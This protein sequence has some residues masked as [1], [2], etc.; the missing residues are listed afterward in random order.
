MAEERI[1]NGIMVEQ[2]DDCMDGMRDNPELGKY[3]FRARNKWVN[4]AHC[5]STIQDFRAAGQE[6]T[7]RARAHVLEGDE[8]TTLLGEDH[9]PN[10]TETLLHALGACLNASFIYHAAAQGIKV[11]ELEFDI[12]G[13][14]DLNGFLGLNEQ[15]PSN[16]QQIRVTCRAKADAPQEKIEELCEYAQK[17]SPVFN[18]VSRPVPVHVVLETPKVHAT[19][20]AQ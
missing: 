2:L 3:Q 9:G 19:G 15:V 12:E 5:R 16:F 14:I 13:D 17:R 6:D 1:V 7:S 18:S 10:A 8:P 20:H 11:Q 4:G